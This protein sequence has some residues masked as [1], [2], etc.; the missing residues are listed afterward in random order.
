MKAP[1]LLIHDLWHAGE[2]T[3]SLTNCSTRE[4]RPCTSHGKH[5]GAYPIYRGVSE[6]VNMGELVPPLIYL[7]VVQVEGRCPPKPGDVF[8]PLT[9]GVRWESCLCGHEIL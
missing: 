6:N 4:N 2:L 5:S 3:P 9:T 8:L 1:L 7:M